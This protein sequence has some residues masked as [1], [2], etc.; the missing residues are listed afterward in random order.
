MRE[1][2]GK[3]KP[4]LT[5]GGGAYRKILLKN[6]GGEPYRKILLRSFDENA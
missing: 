4:F 6:Q 3:A 1:L 5:T 2:N